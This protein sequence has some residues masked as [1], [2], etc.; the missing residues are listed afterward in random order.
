MT[1]Q[2]PTGGESRPLTGNACVSQ[3]LQ[4]CQTS[5][6]A[7]SNST[8]KGRVTFIPP[9]QTTFTGGMPNG[10][11]IVADHYV[12]WT[13]HMFV[14]IH[15]KMPAMFSSP[16]GG[17]A[18]YGNWTMMPDEMWPGWRTNP[19]RNNCFDVTSNPNCKPYVQPSE[20]FL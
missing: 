7:Y 3:T 4:V 14:D 19:L 6:D 12:K 13:S 15:T 5:W 16:Y 9:W 2:R 8:Y 17:C 20:V 18:T 1:T 11:N 10:K